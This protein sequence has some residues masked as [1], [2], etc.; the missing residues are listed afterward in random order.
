MKPKKVLLMLL[1][2]WDPQIPPLG[3]ACLK[4]L[5]TKHGFPV[6][7]ADANVEEELR[8]CRDR[9]YNLL[10]E[11]V[12]LDKR[13]HLYNIGHEVLKNHMTA[14]IHCENEKKYRELVK[15][16]VLKTFFTPLEDAHVNRFIQIIADF[17]KHLEKY[18]VELLDR[19]KPGVLGISVYGGTLGASL[20]TF[21]LAKER[22]PEL[23]T[24]M[25]G[26]VFAGELAVGSPNFQFLLHAAPYIDK[27]IVGEGELL[28][29]YFS[30]YYKV[31]CLAPHQKESIP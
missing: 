22:C 26:G 10:K 20:F 30:N 23:E 25:G 13:R 9:Y 2:F 18:L 17:Y 7:T 4:G 28:F 24:V 12:P 19:E 15:I 1:P 16:L 14:H 31:S 27:I 8:E 3:I 11:Y 21:K 29:P 5:I 6:K